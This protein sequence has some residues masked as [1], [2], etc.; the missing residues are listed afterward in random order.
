MV[1]TGNHK[2]SKPKY[3]TSR[4]F[5]LKQYTNHISGYTLVLQST[6]HSTASTQFA[7]T[8]DSQKII[9]SIL[10]NTLIQEKYRTRN[11]ATAGPVITVSRECGSYGEE[12]ARLC[13]ERMKVNYFDRELV[14]HIAKAAGE[15]PETFHNLE[16]SATGMSPGIFES[17]F[18]NRPWLKV[19]YTRGLVSSLIGV[20][21]IGG[22][23][24]GRGANFILEQDACFRVRIVAPFKIRTARY[25]ERKNIEIA[26]AVRQVKSID[27]ERANFIKALY[28]KNIDQVNAYDLII[29]SERVEI[30][31]ATQMILDGVKN[32]I[33][34]Q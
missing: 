7:M 13:A 10:N 26:E 28:H 3:T 30:D 11:V 5:A 9:Q 22:V 32:S 29:N 1:N 20:S 23:I 33:A 27:E 8:T 12:I 24:I 31:T 16:K 34:C 21:K 2:D 25:A 19:K 14:E 6:I 4:W 15:D 18:T 17:M